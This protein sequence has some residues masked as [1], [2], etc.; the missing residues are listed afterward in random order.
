ML[1]VESEKVYEEMKTIASLQTAHKT[2]LRRN[3]S[4]LFLQTS[5]NTELINLCFGARLPLLMMPGTKN[6]LENIGEFE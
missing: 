1:Q 3:Q 4:L 6:S 5:D 2:F